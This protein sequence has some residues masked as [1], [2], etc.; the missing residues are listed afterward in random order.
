MCPTIQASLTKR[1]YGKA[2]GSHWDMLKEDLPVYTYSTKAIS[3]SQTNEY[4]EELDA[5]VTRK[6][7]KIG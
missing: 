4:Y 6:N 5:H 3:G 2:I 1:E 7:S